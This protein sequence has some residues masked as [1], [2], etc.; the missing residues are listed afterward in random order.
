MR[1]GQDEKSR[2]MS[3][4]LR[5]L[6]L[7]IGLAIGIALAAPAPALAQVPA[8]GPAPAATPGSATIPRSTS[9]G[10]PPTSWH[11][12]AFVSG[13]GT[14]RIIHYW[15]Q[16]ASMRAETL[17]AGHPF[18]TIV[19]GGRYLVIDRLTGTALDIERAPEAL[20]ADEGRP[21]P[22]AFEQTEIALAGGEKVE[23]T[24]LSGVDVEVW[25]VTDDFGRRTAWL[26]KTEPKSPLRVETFVR[27]STQTIKLDYSG[28][29]FNLEIPASFFALPPGI[30]V[31][32]LSYAEYTKRSANGPVG[33]API[34]YPD[35][36]HGGRP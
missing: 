24:K 6:R 12:T 10:G 17:I 18:T 36:L 8:P 7:G 15:S 22:F 25:R 35:L 29:G 4:A 23:D 16:G 31:E 14:Y 30:E 5:F 2:T 28:W 21:R 33:E 19:H 11:A 26:S 13:I 1:V 32:R 3:E 9:P 34:L 27:G 20:A